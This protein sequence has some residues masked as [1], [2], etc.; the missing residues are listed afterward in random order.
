MLRLSSWNRG[1]LRPQ[2]VKDA[3]LADKAASVRVKACGH[4]TAAMIP[5]AMLV[6]V[7]RQDIVES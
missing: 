6:V 5:L 3:E 4:Y 1:K 2:E 7:V